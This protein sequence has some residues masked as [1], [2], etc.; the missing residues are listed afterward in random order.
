MHRD[1]YQ[2][3]SADDDTEA[4]YRRQ[5]SLIRMMSGE[6]SPANP[7]SAVQEAFLAM[8]RRQSSVGEMEETYYCNIC[9]SNKRVSQGY[10]LKNCGHMYCRPCLAGY[11]KS[12]FFSRQI[13][14]RC[15]FID[16]KKACNTPISIDDVKAVASNEAME[17]YTYFANKEKNPNY[18]DCPKCKKQQEGDPRKPWMA[19][20]S[21]GCGQE[22][23][24]VHQLQHGP[25]QSCAEYEAHVRKIE[26][27]NRAWK[28][29]N[30][31]KCPKCGVPT[32][33]NEGCNH[34]TCYVCKTG[35]CWLCG[36]VIGNQ[37]FPDHYKSGDCKGKQFTNEAV[38][39]MS[40]W[41]A[42]CCIMLPAF[43]FLLFSPLAFIM[44]II[45][46]II[47]PLF[48]LCFCLTV[49]IIIFL[50]ILLVTLPFWFPCFIYYNC[51]I[52]P[53][54]NRARAQAIAARGQE[55]DQERAQSYVE[56]KVEDVQPLLG[57]NMA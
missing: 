48:Y 32:E 34:M 3:F 2:S 41:E 10:K 15:F 25:E 52:A 21:P 56:G 29:G 11:L 57:S 53:R 40:P 47:S 45:V 36:E 30:T 24:F 31:K 43:F 42:L 1:N 18:V 6:D 27:Q 13:H 19:C 46:C 23:C 39:Y 54:R 51:A 5:P 20:C 14:P 4:Q 26:A 38:A 9:L 16:E 35:W 12:Q 33:K 55:L 17:K 49:H 7:A 22:F 44:A 8:G 28:A 50:P 37:S